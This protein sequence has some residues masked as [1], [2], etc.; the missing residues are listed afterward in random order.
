MVHCLLQFL[1]VCGSRFFFYMLPHV[2]FLS[3]CYSLPLPI[4]FVLPPPPPSNEGS[5]AI[6]PSLIQ[7]RSQGLGSAGETAGIFT[8]LGFKNQAL[9]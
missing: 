4:P 1:N 8:A 7:E 6:L 5:F 3:T 2:L 9:K